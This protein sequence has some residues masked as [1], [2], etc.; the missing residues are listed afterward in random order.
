MTLVDIRLLLR[1]SSFFDVLSLNSI[2]IAP[3]VIG[4]ASLFTEFQMIMIISTISISA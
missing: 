2:S 4:N 1:E 3:L